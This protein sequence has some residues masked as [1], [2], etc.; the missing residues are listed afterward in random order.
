MT[1]KEYLL[2]SDMVMLK[3]IAK[4]MYPNNADAPS[5]LT[6]KLNNSS[7]RTFTK[8]DAKK[9]LEALKNEQNVIDKL[10]IE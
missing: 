4:K 9:A 5:Y 7:G 1:V 8:A 6:R 3:G 2:E 10:T